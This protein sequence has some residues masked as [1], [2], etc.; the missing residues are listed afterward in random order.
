MQ[1]NP[2]IRPTHKHTHLQATQSRHTNQSLQKSVL[3]A[4]AGQTTEKG[5]AGNIKTNK[6]KH[7]YHHIN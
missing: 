6:Q 5:A 3:L 4:N 2:D 7:I 1:F